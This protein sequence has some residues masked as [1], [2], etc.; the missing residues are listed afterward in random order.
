VGF[1][2]GKHFTEDSVLLDVLKGNQTAPFR[3]MTGRCFVVSGYQ[4]SMEQPRKAEHVPPPSGMLIHRQNS[5]AP[6]SKRHTGRRDAQSRG[7]GQQNKTP[8]FIKK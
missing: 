3:C 2:T 6:R 7:T 1:F 4:L 8:T 5:Y